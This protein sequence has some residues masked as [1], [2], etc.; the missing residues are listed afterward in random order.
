MRTYSS[1]AL[2]VDGKETSKLEMWKEHNIYSAYEYDENVFVGGYSKMME[3]I[4]G[5]KKK[6]QGIKMMLE[7]AGHSA[8][9]AQTF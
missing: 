5:W 6:N 7:A 3:F 8:E 9:F 2:V 1:I 4:E